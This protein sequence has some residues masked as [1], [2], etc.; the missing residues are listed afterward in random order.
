MKNKLKKII[1]SKASSHGIGSIP[2][3]AEGNVLL[4]VQHPVTTKL[5]V[6]FGCYGKAIIPLSSVKRVEE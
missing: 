4:Y 2:L 1:Y 5:L 6:D 3:G